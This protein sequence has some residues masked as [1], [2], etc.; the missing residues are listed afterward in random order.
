MHK[1][2]SELVN[3]SQTPK[4]LNEQA[5]KELKKSK[6]FKNLLITS[7]NILKRLKKV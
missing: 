4:G 2:L 7:N 6:F 1:N 3:T 5:I